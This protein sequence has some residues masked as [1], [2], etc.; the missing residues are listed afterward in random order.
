MTVQRAG[1]WAGVRGRGAAPDSNPLVI[2][3]AGRVE[4]GL[5]WGFLE[6]VRELAL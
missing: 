4:F 6:A 1:G 5:R 2:K 3:W